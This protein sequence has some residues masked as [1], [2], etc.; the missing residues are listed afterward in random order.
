MDLVEVTCHAPKCRGVIKVFPLDPKVKYFC[1]DACRGYQFVITSSK[2]RGRPKKIISKEEAE[3]KAEAKR[4]RERERWRKRQ[5][6]IEKYRKD[7]GPIFEER[8]RYLLKVFEKNN[9]TDRIVSEKTGMNRATINR[10]RSGDYKISEDAFL[11]IKQN[12]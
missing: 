7:M 6:E 1:G 2:P 3:K 8:R 12:W 4:I 5:A 11:K 9:L 10:Y